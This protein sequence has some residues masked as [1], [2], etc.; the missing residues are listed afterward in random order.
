MCIEDLAWTAWTGN[1]AI[2][3]EVCGSAY[4]KRSFVR[5]DG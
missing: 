3:C 2:R 4:L 5:I 1:P